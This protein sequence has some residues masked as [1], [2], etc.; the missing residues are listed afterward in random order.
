MP[1]PYWEALF[2]AMYVTTEKEADETLN[3]LIR[4]AL[5]ENSN[6]GYAEARRIQLS[7]LGWMFGEVAPITRE[8][9]MR[10][11][12]EATHPIFGRSFSYNPEQIMRAGMT[13]AQSMNEGQTL[14]Q[15]VEEGK[16]ELNENDQT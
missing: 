5:K 6:L 16:K 4:L 8:N 2:N 11:Y 3:K 13:I 9:A 15:A 10:M 7:N 12:P 1:T 14:A